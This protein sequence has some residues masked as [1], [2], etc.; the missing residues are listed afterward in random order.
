MSLEMVMLNAFVFVVDYLN[1]HERIKYKRNMRYI[2]MCI[3][4][5]EYRTHI[6]SLM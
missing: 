1:E 6:N 2:H 5:F 3:V 4:T